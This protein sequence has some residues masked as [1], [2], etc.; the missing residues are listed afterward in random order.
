MLSAPIGP[1]ILLAALLPALIFV[2]HWE[3]RI[4]LPGTTYYLGTPASAQQHRH[5]GNDSHT[6]HCHESVATC[7]DTPIA[8]GAVV[9]L[10]A[11][12]VLALFLGGLRHGC[13]LLSATRPVENSTG[14]EP[15]PPRANRHS[16]TLTP[17]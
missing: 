5:D 12:I 9:A 3:V 15:L 4:D 10:L 6:N 2:D 11:S 14:P 17:V 16:L 1:A 8:T 7:S 13:G